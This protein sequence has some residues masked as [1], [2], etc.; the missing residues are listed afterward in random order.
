MDAFANIS[1]GQRVLKSM[2]H[3]KHS[4]SRHSFVPARASAFLSHTRLS[5]VL[6]NLQAPS[7]ALA[8]MA[9]TTKSKVSRVCCCR[10]HSSPFSN[11]LFSFSWRSSAFTLAQKLLVQLLQ[12]FFLLPHSDMDVNDQVESEHSGSGATGKFRHHCSRNC[13]LSSS[14][15]RTLAAGLLVGSAKS[16]GLSC[17]Q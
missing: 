9:L 4:K 6:V 14:A 12:S 17:G 5:Y 16:H 10:S 11:F 15:S 13:C 7:T 2:P 1:D 3:G 8:I